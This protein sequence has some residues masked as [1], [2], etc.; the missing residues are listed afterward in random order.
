MLPL[1]AFKPVEDPELRAKQQEVGAVI[2]EIIAREMAKMATK[3]PE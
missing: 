2:G 1:P 3:K